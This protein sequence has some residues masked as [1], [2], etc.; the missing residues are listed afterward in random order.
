MPDRTKAMIQKKR[1]I[2]VFQVG[3]WACKRQLRQVKRCMSNKNLRDVSDGNRR[4][5]ADGG[6]F[7]EE[8]AA[9]YVDGRN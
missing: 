3:F 9:P 4:M 1:D 6:Q 2:L 5:E 7:L 8:T